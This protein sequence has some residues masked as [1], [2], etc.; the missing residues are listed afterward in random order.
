L[1]YLSRQRMESKAVQAP[2]DL[3]AKYLA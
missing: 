3:E 1:N 2:E